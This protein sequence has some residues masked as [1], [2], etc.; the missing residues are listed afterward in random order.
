MNPILVGVFQMFGSP[1]ARGVSAWTHPRSDLTRFHDLDHWIALATQLD[2]SGFDFLFFADSF[3]YPTI[4]GALVPAAARYG[5]NF[6]LLEPL[7]L[8]PTLAHHTRNLGLVVTETTGLHHPFE[9]ARR[10][11]TLDHLTGGR[12]GM[13]VVTGSIQNVVAQLFGHDEMRQ[14]DDRYDMAEEYLALARDYWERSWDD[15]A[16]VNDPDAP[17]YVDPAKLHRIEHDGTYY[18]S[19]GYLTVDP[20]PQRTPVIFQAGTSG[21]GKA[22][23]AA[24]ADC[25][26]VQGAV[27]EQV[28]ATVADIRAQAVA[29]GRQAEDVKIVVTLSALVAERAEDAAA[30]RAEFDALQSEEVA[31]AMFVS[32]TGIDLLALDPARP[33]SQVPRNEI[34]G[35]MGQSNLD[36]FIAADGSGPTVREILAQLR[37]QGIRGFQLT[38]DPVAVTDEIEE[39]MATTDLDGFL[40][41]PLFGTADV[42]DFA[43]L[44]MPELSQRGRLRSVCTGLTLRERMA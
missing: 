40:L 28:A 44:V 10:F 21:R 14:H 9:T 29:A 6:P 41:D 43:R 42:D 11:A 34:V 19:S 16:L 15:G 39:L 35:Q 13:N 8:I 24:N 17:L 37:T 20:S 38:G 23:A 7:L 1:S 33:L 5:I 3:G 4:D 30:L 26:L 27:P 36:R 31:A 2:D 32:N 22:F 25:V 12:I 18:R